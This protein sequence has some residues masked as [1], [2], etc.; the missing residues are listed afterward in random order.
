M[1]KQ[2]V[3]SSLLL[4]TVVLGGLAFYS[5]TTVKA[6]SLETDVTSVSSGDVVEKVASYSSDEEYTEDTLSE[7]VEPEKD[8]SMGN[9]KFQNSNI[10]GDHAEQFVNIT[11]VEPTPNTVE[12]ITTFDAT[13]W[14]YKTKTGAYYFFVPKNV[15]VTSIKDAQNKE[16][17]TQFKPN[18]DYYKTYSAEQME[19]GINNEWEWSVNRIPSDKRNKELDEWKSK[20]LFSKVYV[21]NNRRDDSSTTFT[22]TA[23]FNEDAE[24]SQFPFV[25]VMKRYKSWYSTTDPASLAA[26]YFE[27]TKVQKPK[28][29]A[30]KINPAP[31]A[32]KPEAPKKEEVPAPPAPSVP[33]EK[34]M[35]EPK[36]ESPKDTPQE[37]PKPTEEPKKEDSPQTP[38]ADQPKVIVPEEKVPEVEQ[39]ETVKPEPKK[40]EVSTPKVEEPKAE[41]P[42]DKVP[43]V[44]TPK[45]EEPKTEVPE[46]SQPKQD[47]PKESPKQEIK[48][49]AETYEPKV[50][51]EWLTYTN[52]T[53]HKDAQKKILDS[54][55]V[56]EATKPVVK[57]IIGD[58]PLE[59]G[60]HA[61]QVKVQYQDNSYDIVIVDV[62]II[63]DAPHETP[64][65]DNQPETKSP[66]VITPKADAPK[67]ERT[68]ETT[69]PKTDAPK[70]EERQEIVKPE[71]D[72]PK[73]E[74]PKVEVP[75]DKFPE[76]NTPKDEE[77]KVD[78]QPETKSPEVTAPKADTP[79]VEQTPKTTEPKTDAPKVDKQSETV[80]PELNQPKVEEPKA[81]VPKDKVPEV[82]TPKVE[83]PK[84]DK[85]P[86]M[87]SPEVRAPKLDQPQMKMP[88][89]PR[90]EKQSPKTSNKVNVIVPER[91][92]SESQKPQTKVGDVVKGQMNKATLPNTGEASGGLTWLGGAL[93]TLVTGL[94]LF[95]NKKE[96]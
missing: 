36:P 24:Q 79:K 25:A 45:V 32:P 81:E 9:I 95:K 57:T 31:E 96:E 5:T 16:L 77:P 91:K 7:D 48:E 61:V 13:E 15:E 78:N 84:V 92:V 3:V 51:S 54:V 69:E 87:K 14:D 28:E 41:V 52:K 11:R 83:E 10:K 88:E 89:V 29:E 37:S 47:A 2:K 74:E 66:E 75:M 80:K 33:E 63:S 44:N 34:P 4:S 82:N 93:A 18:D 26:D 67:V 76:V 65:V 17:L 73:V 71:V 20:A 38:G 46:I 1:S 60:E 6:E 49:D 30:P 85:Q 53:P 56:P 70:V 64:K 72:Q 59:L 62:R 12:W 68:P 42:K 58:V 39:S 86:E 55:I 90:S 19:T 50:L 22:V 40:P 43:E 8:S 94:Y 21:L 23:K 27:K 35:E